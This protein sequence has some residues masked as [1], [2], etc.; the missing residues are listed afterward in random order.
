MRPDH[1]DAILDIENL[2]FP[3]PWTRAVFA[4]HLHH[5][6]FAR[7]IVAIVD[8]SVVGYTGLFYGGGQGQVTNLAVHPEWREYGIGSR[9]LVETFDF[10]YRMNLQGLSLEVRVSNDNAQTLYEKLGFTKVGV[11]KNYYREI[12][13]D[14][15]VMCIFNINDPQISRKYRAR[16]R[17]LGLEE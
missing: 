14:A 7:Y 6:E 3:N 17:G 5:P 1:L 15:Y 9:L 10:S 16:K 2:S 4:G 12:G 11:R 8:E 13:E